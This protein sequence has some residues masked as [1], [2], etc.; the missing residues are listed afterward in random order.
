[1]YEHACE[2]LGPAS[3]D[4]SELECCSGKSGAISVG[5]AGCMGA[6]H[7]GLCSHDERGSYN[8]SSSS[9]GDKGC[10]MSWAGYCCEGPSSSKSNS[11]VGVRGNK[12]PRIRGTGNTYVGGH[13]SILGSGEVL[14]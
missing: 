6:S 11:S 8:S 5:R 3:E 7:D 13:S 2:T 14:G 10:M 12:Q 9:A 1:M 4:Q